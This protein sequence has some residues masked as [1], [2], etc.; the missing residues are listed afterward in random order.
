MTSQISLSPTSREKN[1]ILGLNLTMIGSSQPKALTGRFRKCH[2]EIYAQRPY[3]RPMILHGQCCRR[4]NIT[5]EG[6]RLRATGCERWAESSR[7]ADQAQ[8]KGTW[9]RE[10]PCIYMLFKWQFYEKLTRNIQSCTW[11]TI[12]NCNDTQ[13]RCYNAC[14]EVNPA[15]FRLNKH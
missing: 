11:L 10:H 3:C 8:H 13:T 5:T 14:Q 7:P 12:T 15:S 1:L 2:T 4:M 6:Y 9:L